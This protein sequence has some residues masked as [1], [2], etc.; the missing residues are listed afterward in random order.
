M[1]FGIRSEISYFMKQQHYAWKGLLTYRANAALFLLVSSFSVLSAFITISVIYQVSSGIAGWSYYQMLFLAATGSLAFW[2]V[3]YLINPWT[4]VQG[5][6]RGSLDPYLLRP[7]G[8][9]TVLLSNNYNNVSNVSVISG[10][11]L[12]TYAASHMSFSPF[13]LL[14]YAS[15]LVIGTITIVLFILM[16]TLLAYHVM[17]SAQS[18]QRLLNLSHSISTYPLSVYG[19]AGQLAFTLLFPI[20]LA[21]Y[22]PS[23]VL[24]GEVS[25]GAFAAVSGLS[26]L[27]MV[28][29]YGACNRLV[30][31]YTSGGG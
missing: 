7:Y 20:G 17:K 28:L 25:L 27:M 6:Q 10:L 9:V 21:Y 12:L 11:V 18:V 26:V 24:L 15:L 5:M 16:L 2:A 30:K 29:S 14:E 13:F 4:I 31:K 19:L 8:R 22:Y 1:G 3:G 23:T